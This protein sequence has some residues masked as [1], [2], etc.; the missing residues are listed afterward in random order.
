MTS[1]AMT[2]KAARKADAFVAGVQNDSIIPALNIDFGTAGR[3]AKHYTLAPFVEMRVVNTYN[4]DCQPYAKKD[5]EVFF[6]HSAQRLWDQAIRL[7]LS[8]V[9]S[10]PELDESESEFLKPYVGLFFSNGRFQPG[11][12]WLIGGFWTDLA[13]VF[14]RYPRRS[15]ITRRLSPRVSMRRHM[16]FKFSILVRMGLTP[17]LAFVVLAW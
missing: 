3:S 2:A 15:Q 11:Q 10:Y 14:Q 5:F 4:S 12:V 8:T 16:E 7:P 9:R 6:G 1:R 13:D 17:T